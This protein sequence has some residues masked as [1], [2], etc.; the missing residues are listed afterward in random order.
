MAP[1]IVDSAQF[2]TIYFFVGFVTLPL[3]WIISYPIS[4]KFKRSISPFLGYVISCTLIRALE[5]PSSCFKSLLRLGS[6]MN[7]VFSI[8]FGGN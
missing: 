6:L 1:L 4:C 3:P 7:E 8:P 5:E 2:L